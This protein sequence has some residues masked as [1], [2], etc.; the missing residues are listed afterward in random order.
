M[1][2]KIISLAVCFSLYGTSA[3]AGT[4]VSCPYTAAE[5]K[6]A[7]GVNFKDGEGSET[8][9]ATGKTLDCIYDGSN[10]VTFSVTQTVMNNPSE[11]QGWDAML[12]GKKEKIPGDPDG[13]IRQTDQGDLT[14]PNLHYVRKGDI[15]GLRI[16]GVG[17]TRSPY[18]DP[19]TPTFDVLQ[20]KL[21]SLRKLP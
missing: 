16:L 9:F 4:P 5:L 12:A 14:S 19:K 3:L 11:T 21:E 20:K 7:L 8:R 2:S 13:A 1:N 10:H 17:K 15:V 6:S 18:A